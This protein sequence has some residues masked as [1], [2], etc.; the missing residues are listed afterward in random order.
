MWLFTLF[1]GLVRKLEVG[2]DILCFE[3]QQRED[4]VGEFRGDFEVFQ[5]CCCRDDRF[6]FVLPHQLFVGGRV[7]VAQDQF[8]R[9]SL[10]VRSQDYVI[11]FVFLLSIII[12]KHLI[13]YKW[14][15][16]K[17]C[18]TSFADLAGRTNKPSD[19]LALRGGGWV[20]WKNKIW[21]NLN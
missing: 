5:P 1:D 7:Q 14:A 6:N 4:H 11:G 21:K 16:C 20:V 10:R 2:L 12:M 9:A 3:V 17:H 13:D 15:A 19:L 8:T 18:V